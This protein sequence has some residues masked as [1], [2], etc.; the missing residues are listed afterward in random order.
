MSNS[1]QPHGL[2]HARLPCPTLSPG[3]CS[4]SCPL[5]WWFHPTISSFVVPFSSY[6]QSF[7]ASGSFPISQIFASGSQI[8][9][10]SASVL[11]VNIQYWFP[12]VLIGSISLMS[13]GLSGVFSSTRLWKHQ[14]F[15]AQC[16]IWSNSHDWERRKRGWQRM[17]WLDG[18][19]N[20]MGMS[21]SKFWELVMDRQAWVLQSIGSQGV[22]HDWVTELNWTEQLSFWS[23]SH[24]HTLLLENPKFVSV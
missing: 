6:P 24:I 21:L 12:L 2:Q 13:K 11:P 16:F 9:G 10:A 5:S 19:T 22:R 15:S 14:F 23:N 8:V 3:V 18:I 20:S 17:R 7:L 1:L 4:N